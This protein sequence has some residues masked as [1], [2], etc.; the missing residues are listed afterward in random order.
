[1]IKITIN[2]KLIIYH[3]KL[4]KIVAELQQKILSIKGRILKMTSWHIY[5]IWKCLSHLGIK[6]NYYS[7][8]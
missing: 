2:N 8:L 7:S 1:M 5:D 6:K 4:H 3:R